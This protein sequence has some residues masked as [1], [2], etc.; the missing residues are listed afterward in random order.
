MGVIGPNGAG[1]TT[2][3]NMVTGFYTPD[4]GSMTFDGHNIAGL[5]PNAL[6][7]LGMSRTFQSV[8]LF[9]NMTV[10]EN[11]MVGRHTR[12]KAGFWGALFRAGEQSEEEK[13]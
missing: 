2:L 11:A 9:D 13:T 5:K 10:L 1:K 7:R 3:F 8:R 12:T 4:T 6:T